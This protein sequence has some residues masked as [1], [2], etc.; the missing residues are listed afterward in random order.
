MDGPFARWLIRHGETAWTVSGQHRGR[1]APSRRSTGRDSRSK[2]ATDVPTGQG[3]WE[4]SIG[5]GR[6]TAGRTGGGRGKPLK[7]NR[8]TSRPNSGALKTRLSRA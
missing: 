3:L 4:V 6:P 2:I 1:T 5:R 7:L 8:V